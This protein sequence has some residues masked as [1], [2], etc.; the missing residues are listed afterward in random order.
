MNDTET[1]NPHAVELG[2]LIKR[3]RGYHQWTQH[4]LATE[5]GI[6]PVAI[7]NHETG[8]RLPTLE[9]M[10]AY[11]YALGIDPG[12]V[13]ALWAPPEPGTMMYAMQQH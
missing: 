10:A 9:T 4:Q 2:A 8:K 6:H 12:E 11:V 3:Y 7:T 5:S 1:L 13:F